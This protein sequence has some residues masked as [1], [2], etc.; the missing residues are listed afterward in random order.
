MI[1]RKY[2]CEEKR[3]NEGRY[4]YLVTVF[5]GFFCVCSGDYRHTSLG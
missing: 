2:K 3:Y 4:Y 5:W 1:V